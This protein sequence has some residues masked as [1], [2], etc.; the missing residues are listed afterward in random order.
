MCI[1]MWFDLIEFAG[2]D[3]MKYPSVISAAGPD[4]T[5]FPATQPWADPSAVTDGVPVIA[6]E[7]YVAIA[8][9]SALCVASVAR[10]HF[11]D[12]SQA[13]YVPIR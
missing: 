12:D 5:A 9:A 10:L 13:Q 1:Q 8:E 11:V 3:D 7:A 4:V 2:W 6:P